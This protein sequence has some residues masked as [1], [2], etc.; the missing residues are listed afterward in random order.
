MRPLIVKIVRIW[1]KL[2]SLI[3]CAGY[4]YFKF[5]CCNLV[6]MYLQLILWFCFHFFDKTYS[7]YS[8]NLCSIFFVLCPLAANLLNIVVC[9]SS[10]F[11]YSSTVFNEKMDL[12]WYIFSTMSNSFSVFIFTCNCT[13]I[14]YERIFNRGYVFLQESK[15][16]IQRFL[17]YAA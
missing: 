14:T 17:K 5:V 15:A 3:L 12:H 6:R 10:S 9:H 4:F 13:P 8:S 1:T 2:G 16:L 7:T 11:P